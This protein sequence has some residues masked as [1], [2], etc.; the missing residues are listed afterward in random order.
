MLA[1]PIDSQTTTA[2]SKLYGNAPFFAM[3][4]LD[5]GSFNVVKNQKK[6]NGL[7]IAPFLKGLGVEGTIYKHMGQGVYDSFERL[8]IDVFCCA[9]DS[10][11]L[12]DIYQGFKKGSFEKLD[13][14][15]FQTLLH[16]GE[17][18][19]CKCGCEN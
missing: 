8:G 13:A 3:M 1:I 4:N 11:S 14:N 16:P 5:D 19:A 17:G 6:G 2:V 7:E 9:K 10:S 12:E 15:N 18:G